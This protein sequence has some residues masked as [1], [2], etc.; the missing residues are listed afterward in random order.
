MS[1][2]PCG[3]KRNLDKCCG[4]IIAGEPAPTAEKLMRSRFTAFFHG[5]MDYVAKTQAEPL[6]ADRGENPVEWVGLTVLGASGGGVGENSG[7]VEFKARFR[8]D[9]RFQVFHE[10]S[11]F[12]REDGRWLYIDGIIKPHEDEVPTAKTGRNDPCLCGSGRK[13]KKCCGG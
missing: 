10:I 4:P 3:S 6:Q 7:T 1:T 9:G 12:R 8:H 11:N 13:Y 5:N 2:C